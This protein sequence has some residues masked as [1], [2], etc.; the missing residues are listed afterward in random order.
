MRERER[1]RDRKSAFRVPIERRVVPLWS[2][3]ISLPLR[4]NVIASSDVRKRLVTV[5]DDMLTLRRVEIAILGR[6]RVI[7]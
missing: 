1:E 4:L 7:E 5:V 2:E 3:S 6:F